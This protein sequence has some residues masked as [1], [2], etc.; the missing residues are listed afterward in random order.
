[1]ASCPAPEPVLAAAPASSPRTLPA[2]LQG[3][4]LRLHVTL[5]ARGQ[6]PCQGSGYA[7]TEL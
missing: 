6:T 3:W 7:F 4:P 2:A 1:M 5:S